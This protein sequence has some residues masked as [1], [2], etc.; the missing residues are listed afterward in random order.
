MSTV[1]AI[2]DQLRRPLRD[3]RISVTDQCNFRCTY[4]M[5][6][7][8]F[9]PNFQFM[10]K[11]E[12]LTFEE[13]EQLVRCFARLGVVK[14]RLTGGEPLLRK[15][16]H[17]FI[18]RLSKIEQIEDVAL[19]TNGV[20][21]TKYAKLLKTSGLRRVNVSLDAIDDDVFNTINGRAIG[22]SHILKGIESARNA[23]LEAKVNMV[24]KRG[25]NEEQILPMAAHFKK[26]GIC[27]RYIEFMDV[28][29]TNEW[30]PSSVVTKKEILAELSQHFKLTPLKA[31][32]Y[33]EVA[34][35]YRYADSN[36]EVGFIP[37]VSESFCSNCTRARI[38]AEGKLYTCLFATDGFDLRA[39]LRKGVSDED[40]IEIISRI[41]GKRTDRY[42]DLRKLSAKKQKKKIEMHY[43]G[44]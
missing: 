20:L 21:L 44:G 15:D 40:L 17:L 36:T 33:G 38:S 13:M 37:S 4:C 12:R 32:Y 19:T 16:L 18:E 25:M 6:A 14:V 27:L 3:L 7:E 5:P 29:N 24:V 8:I 23:G 41:W 1:N 30:N 43:I 31:A 26:E 9:G 2:R 28:G 34:N 10:K 35:R 39:L 11:E 22:V 42:S